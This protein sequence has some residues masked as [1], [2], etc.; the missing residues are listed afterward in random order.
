MNLMS[1]M[2]QM[3]IPAKGRAFCKN[4]WRKA[5]GGGKEGRMER[6]WQADIEMERRLRA[7]GVPLEAGEDD[8][9]IGALPAYGLSITQTGECSVF[10]L[11]P[12]GVG[13]TI[14]LRIVPNL[15]WPFEISTIELALP[16][17]DSFLY[18][19][20]DPRESDA[21]DGMYW[22]PARDPL[23]YPRDQVINHLVGAGKRLSRGRPFGGLLVGVGAYMPDTILQGS[24]VPVLVR[25]SDQF[26]KQYSS[27]FSLRASRMDA[28][29]RTQLQEKRATRKP[30]F[31][32]PD[33]EKPTKSASRETSSARALLVKQGA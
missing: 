10:D 22:F 3:H 33:P 6:K 19:I 31:A 18:W 1:L 21:K 16:W 4:T 11:D 13:Y 14:E 27:A 17:E 5:A 9:G 7:A 24:E 20:P 32:C 30:L 23:G 2:Y 25:M 26:G 12:C 8:G 15:P 29:R 28:S